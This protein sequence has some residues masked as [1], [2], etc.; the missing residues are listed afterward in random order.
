VKARARNRRAVAIGGSMSGLFAAP[1]GP[2]HCGENLSAD[3]DFMGPAPAPR[4]LVDHRPNRACVIQSTDVFV[5]RNGIV[6]CTDY[7]AGLYIME[8]LG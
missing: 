5:H 3:T 4:R 1:Q 2:Y 8:Y 6:Y 7:N